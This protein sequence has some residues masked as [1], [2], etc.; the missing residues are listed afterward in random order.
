MLIVS[1]GWDLGLK[2]MALKGE[3]RLTIPAALAY[4]KKGAPP[5]IPGNATL[6][7]EG[8]LRIFAKLPKSSTNECHPAV[9]LVSL[10]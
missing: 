1:I 8:K 5:D 2:G 6:I 7:F 10:K 9:K 3:R 4:G